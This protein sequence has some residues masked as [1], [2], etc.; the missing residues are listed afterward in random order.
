MRQTQSI[1]KIDDELQLPLHPNCVLCDLKL[2]SRDF[3]GNANVRL[4]MLGDLRAAKTPA[5]NAQERNDLIRY[6]SIEGR[7]TVNFCE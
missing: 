2:R 3:L 1:G 6:I 7:V 5:V 4:D